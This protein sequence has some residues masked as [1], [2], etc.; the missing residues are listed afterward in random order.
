MKKLVLCVDNSD[1][2]TLASGA[3]LG[4]AKK[5]GLEVTG[6]HSYNAV[7]HEGAFKMMEPILPAR[8]QKEEI[9]KKQREVHS[10][11]ISVGMQKISLSYL[12]PHQAEFEAAGVTFTGK[13]AEGKNF[14]ALEGLICAEDPDITV[15]GASGFSDE[16]KSVEGFLGSVCLRVVRDLDRDF[17]VVKKPLNLDKPVYVVGLDGSAAALKTLASAKAL[18]VETGATLHLV[19]VFD[20]KLHRDIFAKLKD[21]L[22]N[23]EGFKFNTAAQD[24]NHDEF[25]DKGLLGVGMKILSRAVDEV[26][27]A[28]P[29]S[30]CPNSSGDVSGVAGGMGLVGNADAT[31]RPPFITKVLEGYTHKRICEYAAEVGADM[32]FV[33]RTGRHFIEGMDLGST[34]ENV[35]RYAPANVFVTGHIKH[36]GWR[37]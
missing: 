31:L 12:R 3:A 21:A 33:G 14:K 23:S 4:L 29:N 19:Y 2:S 26:L 6:V 7:M 32:I 20:T 5:L 35:L 37:I 18:A 16:Y 1:G 17:L 28:A 15:I 30:S 22:I 34:A 9:L 13:V 24:K 10:S 36:D 8:F 25:I 11:L 27:G